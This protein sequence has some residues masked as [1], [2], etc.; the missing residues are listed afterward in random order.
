MEGWSKWIERRA[1]PKTV[2]RYACSLDQLRDFLDG[3][4]SP[5]SAAARSPTSSA[6]VLLTA[7]AM[8][9]SS[10]IWSRCRA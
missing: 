1:R 6:L 2:E 7:S 4:R 9:P 10:A 8:P 5:T 3:R